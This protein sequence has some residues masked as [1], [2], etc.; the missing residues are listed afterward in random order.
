M[1]GSIESYSPR[2]RRLI[3]RFVYEQYASSEEI[4]VIDFVEVIS[5]DATNVTIFLTNGKTL[6]YKEN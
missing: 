1:F 5:K 4:P 6:Y 2:K 3:K